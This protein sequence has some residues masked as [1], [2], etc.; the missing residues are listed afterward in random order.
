M[1]RRQLLTTDGID[2]LWYVLSGQS[3]DSLDGG[4]LCVSD[5]AQKAEAPFDAAPIVDGGQIKVSAT[6]GEQV[7]NFDWLERDI[8][9]AGGVVL[10]HQEQDRGRKA[11]GSVWTL[12]AALEIK[13]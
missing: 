6:F 3:T 8:I 10:D 4:S 13:P 11:E 5:G 7:A 2:L 9:S 12:D 1:R